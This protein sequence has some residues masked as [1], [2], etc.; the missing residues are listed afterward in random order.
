MF[1]ILIEFSGTGF[2]SDPGTDTDK[3]EDKYIDPNYFPNCTATF[4]SLE[5]LDNRKNTVPP[6]CIEK[7]LFDIQI[8][9]ME[10]ALSSYKDI[11]NNGYDKK[12]QI[13]QDYIKDQIPDELYNF[14]A[15]DKVDKYFKCKETKTGHCCK[16]CSWGGCAQDCIPGKD[17]TSGLVTN[18]L[19][20]CPQIAAPMDLVSGQ[21][22]PNTTFSLVD[23]NGFFG[24]LDSSLGINQSWISFGSRDMQSMNGCQFAGKDVEQCIAQTDHFFYDYPLADN[25]KIQVFN[26]KDIIQ[27][28]FPKMDDMIGNFHVMQEWN[29]LDGLMLDSDLVDATSLPAF[30]AQ[31]AVAN[32][33][34]IVDKVK[35]IQKKQREELILD[36]LSGALMLIPFVGEEASAAGLVAVG[37]ALRLLT[38]IGDL[39]TTIYTVVKDPKNA[40]VAVFGY[41]ATA[42][43]GRDGY[44]NAAET[45]RHMSGDEYDKLGNVKTHLDKVQD[46]LGVTCAI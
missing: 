41:L 17:C 7:Y 30:S 32:M 4:S 45:R 46:F 8:S 5:D 16:D 10:T 29:D 1:K 40:F 2:D 33:Q 27:A 15:S 42:G 34:A 28:A 36:F 13:Y 21:Q 31:E 25:D 37:Q 26:P 44:K 19:P 12:F 35:D 18:D 20:K 14:M 3:D 9:V 6:L 22:V 23:S 11:I 38:D 43:V 24:E 39:A